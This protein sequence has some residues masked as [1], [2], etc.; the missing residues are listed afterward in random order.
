M[1]GTAFLVPNGTTGF[2]KEVTRGTTP[3][4]GTVFYVPITDPV[5]APM[6]NW[7]KDEALRGSPVDLY[8]VVPA[9]R[10][11]EFDH[12]SWLYADTFPFYMNALLG[13]VDTVTTTTSSY[14]HSIPLLNNAATGSQPASY[15]ICNFDG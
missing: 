7:I 13:G 3:G 9:A 15:S 5:V 1:A 8:N 6:I 10:H 11:D 4:S 14:S 2:V 12:K